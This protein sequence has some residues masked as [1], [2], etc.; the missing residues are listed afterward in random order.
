MSLYPSQNGSDGDRNDFSFNP[1]SCNSNNT[2]H[3][4]L[5]EDSYSIKEFP[6]PGLTMERSKPLV[7]FLLI[8]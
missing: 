6:F 3:H 7:A 4:G 1:S 8:V 5:Y 2:V